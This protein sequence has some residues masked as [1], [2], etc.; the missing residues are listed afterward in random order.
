VLY[1]SEWLRS[2]AQGTAHA[3]KDVEQWE[4]SSVADGIANFYN[5]CGK[6]FSGFSENWEYFYFKTLLGIYPKVVLPY[7]KNM[8]STMFRA[9]FFFFFFF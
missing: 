6:Q 4:Y 7:H 3:G 2:K 5:H 1:P 8:C 9:A